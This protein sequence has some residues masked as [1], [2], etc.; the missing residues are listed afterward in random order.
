M[1]RL[2]VRGRRKGTSCERMSLMAVS[3][4]PRLLA[5]LNLV[6]HGIKQLAD[7]ADGFVRDLCREEIIVRWRIADIGLITVQDVAMLY[8][9]TELFIHCRAFAAKGA[10]AVQFR[11]GSSRCFKKSFECLF[12]ALTRQKAGFMPEPFERLEK[13]LCRPQVRFG[14]KEEARVI[15]QTDTQEFEAVRS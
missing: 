8:E 10:Q 15:V 14:V 5:L 4:Q 13:S 9:T 3:Q 11:G 7:E 12:R 2:R 6:A 1:R